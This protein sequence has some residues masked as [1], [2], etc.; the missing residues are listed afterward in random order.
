[1]VSASPAAGE[2]RCGVPKKH[3]PRVAGKISLRCVV[4]VRDWF[5]AYNIH[6]FEQLSGTRLLTSLT[7][8]PPNECEI[9]TM[10]RCFS[11]QLIRTSVRSDKRLLACWKTV[12]VDALPRGWSISTSYPH[13]NILD[14][15]N[16]SGSKSCGQNICFAV[17]W[18]AC[19]AALFSP[20]KTDAD[21][22]SLSLRLEREKSFEIENRL[23]CFFGW[24][25]LAASGM[26]TVACCSLE[27]FVVKV[28]VRLRSPK[29]PWTNIMLQAKKKQELIYDTVC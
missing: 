24:F 15:G 2:P 3:T 9:K 21:S 23:P 11:S 17:C 13:V 22:T 26:Y 5:K 18:G 20:A 6:E 19:T 25:G 14:F 27:F 29:S 16:L 8:I 10:G 7:T 28:H 4:A 12:A 1:M